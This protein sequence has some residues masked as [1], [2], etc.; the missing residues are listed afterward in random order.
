[1]IA[2]AKL[3]PKQERFVE[4][5]L[6][7]LNATQAAIRAEYDLRNCDSVK[8]YYVYLLI[9]P[10]DNS[11]FYVGKGKSERYAAHY[12]E[13]ASRNIIN[14]AKH[15]R[16]E[17]IVSEG[18]KPLPKCFVDRLDEQAAYDTEKEL[19]RG[20]GLDRLTNAAPGQTSE[21]E[22]SIALARSTLRRIKPFRQWMSERTRT[23]YE[24][25]LYWKCLK[26]YRKIAAGT[27]YTEI[28][29]NPGGTIAKMR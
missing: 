15:E 26:E 4:E 17:G 2:V 24:Q 28:A 22:K 1:V 10:R 21:R 12:K 20:I 18:L 6:V 14:A 23:P 9:D 29:I 27:S 19:I 11:V 5:Y 3:T 7:D 25:A 13:W 16:I 8:G